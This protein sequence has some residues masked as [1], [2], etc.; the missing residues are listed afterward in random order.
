MEFQ[1]CNNRNLFL[2]KKKSK[3]ANG[4]EKAMQRWCEWSSLIWQ[5]RKAYEF[6]LMMMIHFAFYF[7]FLHFTICINKILIEIEIEVKIQHNFTYG[8]KFIDR[9][10]FSL[11]IGLIYCWQ[12]FV[13]PHTKRLRH[14]IKIIEST[15]TIRIEFRNEIES[16]SFIDQPILV[17]NAVPS[18]NK[19]LFQFNTKQLQWKRMRIIE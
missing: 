2:K 8:W 16:I 1:S 14:K 10:V 3:V 13:L 6:R 4:S 5:M 19:I 18:A 15:I 12:T 11:C 9:L 7:F 17:C